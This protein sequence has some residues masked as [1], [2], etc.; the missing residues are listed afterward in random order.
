[1][2]LQ[3]QAVRFEGQIPSHSVLNWH[4]AKFLVD[5]IGVEREQPKRAVVQLECSTSSNLS[6]TVKFPHYTINTPPFRSY[7][8]TTDS[9]GLANPN[10]VTVPFENIYQGWNWTIE[11]DLIW[12]RQFRDENFSP[13]DYDSKRVFFKWIDL[14][15]HFEVTP[16]IA[17]AMVFSDEIQSNV[18]HIVAR[19]FDARWLPSTLWVD[20]AIDGSIYISDPTAVELMSYLTSQ[21]NKQNQHPQLYSISSIHID[22]DWANDG[23]NFMVPSQNQTAMEVLL[24][25]LVGASPKLVRVPSLLGPAMAD[26]LARASSWICGFLQDIRHR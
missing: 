25:G 2:D 26:A 22:L 15:S 14:S 17:A 12:P 10:G 18:T 8:A 3:D 1:M 16:S 7:N 6:A 21:Q 13:L 24:A 23:L 5:A 9:G 11:L 20:S 4:R 19:S